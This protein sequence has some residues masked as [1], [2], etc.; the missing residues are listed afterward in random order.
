MIEGRD[1]LHAH[2]GGVLRLMPGFRLERPGRPDQCH[3]MVRSAWRLVDPAGRVQAAG[4]D[5]CRLDP[6][7]RLAEATGFWDTT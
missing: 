5:Y 2:I 4:V 6:D 1:A 7:G 3:M